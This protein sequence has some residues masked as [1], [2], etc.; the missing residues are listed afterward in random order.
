MTPPVQPM[1][2]RDVL[3]L[4][5]TDLEARAKFGRS[6]AD[7]YARVPVIKEAPRDAT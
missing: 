4:A 6:V 1:A 3:T 5:I 7:A 2:G